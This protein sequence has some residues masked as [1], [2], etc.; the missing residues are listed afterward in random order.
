MKTICIFIALIATGCSASPPTTPTEVSPPATI[1]A[2]SAVTTTTT[3]APESTPASSPP[4]STP[5]SST[6]SVVPFENCE[7]AR[8]AGA[9]PVYEGDPGWALGLDRDGDGVGCE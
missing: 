2:T 3:P 9:T 6:T 5:P 4:P 7:E 1:S 8:E